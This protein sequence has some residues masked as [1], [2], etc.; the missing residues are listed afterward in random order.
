MI[1]KKTIF[2]K[3]FKKICLIFEK[4]SFLDGNV[5]LNFGISKVDVLIAIKD[6][7]D[8][9]EIHTRAARRK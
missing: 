6:R 2:V 7:V 1:L 9:A 8:S 4:I 3:V 5:H